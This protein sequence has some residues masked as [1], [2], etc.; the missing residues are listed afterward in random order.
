MLKIISEIEVQVEN[1]I[2][3]LH[4]DPQTPLE[5][6][7]K[8]LLQYLQIIGKIKEQNAAKA[9]EQAQAAPEQTPAQEPP[10]A[11]E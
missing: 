7:E 8:M 10:K 3:R 6:A 4:L 5:V 1:F 11:A 9:Q 2:A